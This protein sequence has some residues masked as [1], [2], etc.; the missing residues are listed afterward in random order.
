VLALFP[1]QH[2]VRKASE[3][4]GEVVLLVHHRVTLLDLQSLSL[5]HN[6]HILEEEAP[7]DHHIPID[8]GL[9]HPLVSIELADIGCL[10]EYLLIQ[11]KKL[12]QQ[13][14]C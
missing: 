2:S 4:P 7:D 1:R 8:V 5:A 12:V 14:H 9:V 13:L 3:Q 6:H 10:G 11:T